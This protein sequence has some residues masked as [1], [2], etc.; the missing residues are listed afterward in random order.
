[1]TKGTAP[2]P[3]LPPKS[4]AKGPASGGVTVGPLT[5]LLIK[6]R[7]RIVDPRRWS[8]GAYARDAQGR[9]VNV[10]DPAAVCWCAAGSLEFEA[11][12][13]TPSWEPPPPGSKPPK[14][15]PD[16]LYHAA[17]SLLEQ[18]GAVVVREVHTHA[19]EEQK[20]TASI[21]AVNDGSGHAAV[22]KMYNKAIVLAKGK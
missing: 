13:A 9:P 17:H 8:R 20:K 4:P 12:R 6:S 21:T 1:M 7:Q 2:K 3:K 10:Q 16:K 15:E 14:K 11:G 22:M 5:Q 19:T 18:A